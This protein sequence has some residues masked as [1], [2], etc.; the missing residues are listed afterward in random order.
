[1]MLLEQRSAAFLSKSETP[2]FRWSHLNWSSVE[3][4]PLTG[5]EG[6]NSNQWECF[7][8]Y[9]VI[10]LKLN[11]S[12]TRG[13][14][15]KETKK[16]GVEDGLKVYTKCLS[17]WLHCK[18]TFAVLSTSFLQSGKMLTDHAGKWYEL[19][20]KFTVASDWVPTLARKAAHTPDPVLYTLA[21]N[22]ETSS[23]DYK[24]NI[25]ATASHRETFP[26]HW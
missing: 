15:N 16:E 10:S 26:W 2:N 5:A 21:W 4:R 6:I 18:L 11:K 20:L 24:S 8:M 14:K 9:Q 25:K 7:R 19:P 1:M 17:T 3:K 22:G 23:F 12:K 13:H